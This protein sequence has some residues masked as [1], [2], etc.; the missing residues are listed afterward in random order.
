MARYQIKVTRK[1]ETVYEVDE[2]R[3]GHHATA[4]LAAG[5]ALNNDK[6]DGVEVVQVSEATIDTRLSTP[7]K[8]VSAQGSLSGMA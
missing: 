7:A 2:C 1:I 4:K 8:V 5:L 3:S 6:A